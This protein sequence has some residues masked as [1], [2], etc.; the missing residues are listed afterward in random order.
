MATIAYLYT[1]A[2]TFSSTT[3]DSVLVESEPN[4][5][6]SQLSDLGTLLFPQAMSL[7]PFELVD[8]NG[9][10]F[11]NTDLQGSWNLL[12]FG[13]TA[14][15]DICPITMS[16]LQKFY[17][18]LEGSELI[19]S[20]NV[21]L[22][23]IDPFN[24]NPEKMK[25]YAESFHGHFQGLTGDYTS[26]SRLAKELFISHDVPPMGKALE[27]PTTKHQ[28]K[29]EQMHSQHSAHGQEAGEEQR[30]YSI[31]HSGHVALINDEGEFQGV[32]RFPHRYRLMLEAY[33]KIRAQP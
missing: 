31:E 32:M 16:E 17:V 20:T 33:T 14:C 7:S 2:P 29:E 24:D 23:S 28:P 19:N 10:P 30:S 4:T 26:V 3:S 9:K 27:Q 11:T 22:V 6:S 21:I 15:P 5:M 8:K 25:A 1:G 12:F 18:G 13:F